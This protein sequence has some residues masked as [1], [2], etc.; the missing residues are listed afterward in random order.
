MYG[1]PCRKI[2]NTRGGGTIILLLG[3]CM[4][5]QILFLKQEAR[6]TLHFAIQQ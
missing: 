4:Y 1:A 5:W 3:T 6:F 2:L